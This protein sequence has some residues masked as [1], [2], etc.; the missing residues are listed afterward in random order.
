MKTCID[1]KK[2]LPYGDFVPKKS[3]KDGYEI[4]CR[5]CRSIKYNK[6]SPKLLAKRMYL[7]QC[8]NSVHRGHALPQYTLLDFTNWLINQPNFQQLFTEWT[9]SDYKKE[10]APS[11][12][13]LDNNLPYS[14]ENL[15]LITWESNRKNGHIARKNN[16]F[17]VN[18]RSVTAYNLDGT[19]YKKYLSMADA[20]REFGGKGSQ[21]WGISTVCEGVPVKDGK[22]YMYTPKTY[23]NLIWK[24]S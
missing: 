20:V 5:S 7:S 16:E 6:S 18:Q 24:W 19:V 22:G 1:C 17:L 10:L 9:N 23:K 15:Q 13:R 14:F 3:C 2:T 12:D 21:S 8:N 11:A 4:R